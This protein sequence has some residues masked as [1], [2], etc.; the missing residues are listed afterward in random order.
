MPSFTTAGAPHLRYS[1]LLLVKSISL[2]CTLMHVVT[3]RSRGNCKT[4]SSTTTL[5]S[6]QGMA[7]MP[8]CSAW[9]AFMA[10]AKQLYRLCMTQRYSAGLWALMQRFS[11]SL[12]STMFTYL[13]RY[14]CGTSCALTGMTAHH[15]MANSAAFELLLASAVLASCCPTLPGI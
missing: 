5:L 2:L 13:L 10:V 1:L 3:C 15:S 12:A 8:S 9:K 4:Y 6:R 7:Y 14:A 11:E